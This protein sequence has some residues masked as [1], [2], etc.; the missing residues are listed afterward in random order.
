MR[1]A[2]GLWPRADLFAQG[3]LRHYI[4]RSLT[5]DGLGAGVFARSVV[6]RGK[7]HNN[8]K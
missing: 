7:T 4:R 1:A 6:D 5:S 2:G 8:T 3:A